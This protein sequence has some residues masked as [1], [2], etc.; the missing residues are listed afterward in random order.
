MEIWICSIKALVI[1]KST[2]GYEKSGR[3]EALSKGD[4]YYINKDNIPVI[5]HD[6]KPY[7]EGVYGRMVNRSLGRKV[8]EIVEIKRIKF[9]SMCLW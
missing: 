3:L 6:D 9:S 4:Y 7:L 8:H 2:K 1:I 5:F